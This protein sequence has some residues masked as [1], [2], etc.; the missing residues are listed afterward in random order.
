MITGTLRSDGWT[1]YSGVVETPEKDTEAQTASEP[2]R[3]IYIHQDLDDLG[4]TVDAFRVYAHLARRAGKKNFAYPSY[5]SI[6]EHC[7][8]L[9]YPKA[10]TA[11]L[12]RKAIRAVAELERVG[13]IAVQRRVGKGFSLKAN[14]SNAYTILPTSMWNPKAVQVGKDSEFEQ[15]TEPE[16]RKTPRRN[17]NVKTV[18]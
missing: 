14:T 17:R 3:P 5:T 10:L 13:I 9:S 11:S 12:R 4:L 15:S 8:R 2:R 1:L 18:S 16:P 6:G 7:F